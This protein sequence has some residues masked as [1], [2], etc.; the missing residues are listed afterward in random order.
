VIRGQ[1]SPVE[2]P[3]QGFTAVTARADPRAD[4]VERRRFGEIAA[5]EGPRLDA[6]PLLHLAQPDPMS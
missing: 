4:R 3:G 5:Y 6:P 1:L 2:S